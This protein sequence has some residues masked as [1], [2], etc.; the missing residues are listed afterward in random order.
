MLYKII[1][2]DRVL[3]VFIIFLIAAGIWVPAFLSPEMVKGNGMDSSM[4]LYR[5]F[6]DLLE[7]RML[8]SKM[9]AFG[10]MIFEA[11]LLVRINARLVL[12]QQKTF[13][14]ALFFIIIA[15]NTSDLLQWNPV[16]PAALFVIFV[17]ELIFRSNHDE[18]NSY[19]YFEVGML[20]G[21]GSLF[22][23]PLI[24]MIVFIWIGCAIQR[25]FYWREYVF[26]VLGFAVPYIFVFSIL[27]MRDRS[28][29]EFLMGM[30]SDFIFSFDFP[31]F[32][33]SSRV[34]SIYL[35]LLVL[36]S[37]VFLLKVFQF[38]KIYIRDYFLVL[39]W[40]FI[41]SV[42][43]FLLLSGFNTGMSYLI[44]ISI[45]YILTNY[46]VNARK[47]VGNM[48][49]LYLLLGYVVAMGVVNLIG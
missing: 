32:N 11:F 41:L 26:P 23:A 17:L 34:F 20:L 39:F 24:Y 8:L 35:G 49:L 47:S 42:L 22:Y 14:P 29:P 48:V 45:S 2:G 46:F 43:F 28:I 31:D 21:I 27:F 13:L 44:G 5:F 3:T 16:L 7:G 30:K 19:K 25:P 38:R 33:W 1:T 18:P 10:L 37:S 9:F 40:L 6:N 12:V 15:G 4:P 36:V